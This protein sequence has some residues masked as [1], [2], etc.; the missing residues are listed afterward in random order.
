MDTKILKSI[1][2][3]AVV[4]ALGIGVTYAQFTS[5]AVTITGTQAT[6]GSAELKLCHGAPNGA[7]NWTTT[8]APTLTATN[9]VPGGNETEL[10]VGDDVYVGNDGGDLQNNGLGG[11]CDAYA[12]GLEA[13]AGSSDV[14]MD[15]IPSLVDLDCG[16]D[17][18]LADEI[19]LRIDVGGTS[20]TKTLTDWE[21]NTTDT[22]GVSLAPDAIGEITMFATLDSTSDGQD[23]TC[24]FDLSISGEQII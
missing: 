5:Q 3:I 4:A 15:L 11:D 6:T 10:T 1:L 13:A 20:S 16:G 22:L 24:D 21:L 8:I 14:T 7:D 17:A 23:S 18:A 19:T 2:T 9:L 12:G